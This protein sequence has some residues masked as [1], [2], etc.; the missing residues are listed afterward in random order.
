MRQIFFLLFLLPSLAFG[1]GWLDSGTYKSWPVT[2]VTWF[3]GGVTSGTVSRISGSTD[4]TPSSTD[5]SFNYSNYPA[6]F[7]HFY[8]PTNGLWGIVAERTN[9]WVKTAAT[10]TNPAS[11][12][13]FVII[14]NSMVTLETNRAVV[15]AC[16]T[17]P[18]TNNYVW[19]NVSNAVD[20]SVWMT[21]VPQLIEWDYTPLVNTNHMTT[22]DT[23]NEDLTVT[24]TTNGVSAYQ[25]I[26][27]WNI[28]CPEIWTYDSTL[29]ANEHEDILGITNQTWQ[30]LP[31][32]DSIE[33]AAVFQNLPP[34]KMWILSHAADFVMTIFTNS[35]GTFDDY[36]A[37]PQT[38]IVWTLRSGPWWNGVAIYAETNYWQTNITYRPPPQWSDAMYL[39]VSGSNITT[40]QPFEFAP[41]LTVED[42]LYVA[43]PLPYH[44][45]SMVVTNTGAFPGWRFGFNYIQFT[46]LTQI[47][48]NYATVAGYFRNTPDK[49]HSNYDCG[50]RHVNTNHWRFG[51]LNGWLPWQADGSSSLDT[52]VTNPLSTLGSTVLNC[53]IPYYS[54]GW[55]GVN[56]LCSNSIFA[57]YQILDYTIA[58]ATNTV[59]TATNIVDTTNTSH[60]AI[61]V[62]RMDYNSLI[63]NPAVPCNSNVLFSGT[64]NTSNSL[65]VAATTTNWNVADGYTEQAYEF[66]GIRTCLNSLTQ[67]IS[68][69][70]TWYD[71][72]IAVTVSNDPPT[73]QTL[74]ITND[75]YLVNR[76]GSNSVSSLL[77]TNSMGALWVINSSITTATVTTNY[78]GGDPCDTAG[79]YTYTTNGLT[80]VITVVDCSTTTTDY[81]WSV[82]NTVLNAP[83]VY[84]DTLALAKSAIIF[85]NVNY[86]DPRPSGASYA[87]NQPQSALYIKKNWTNSI[88]VASAP[89]G[90]V[91][92]YC[93]DGIIVGETSAYFD[94]C[95]GTVSYAVGSGLSPCESATN[96]IC[97][98]PPIIV[99]PALPIVPCFCAIPNRAAAVARCA[100]LGG[101]PTA[102][103]LS[104]LECHV[105]MYECTNDVS[106]WPTITVSDCNLASVISY[107][108]NYQTV[109][110]SGTITQ[111]GGQNVYPMWPDQTPSDFTYCCVKDGVAYYYV[112]TWSAGET[113]TNSM[114]SAYA[115]ST[116]AIPGATPTSVVMLFE[117]QQSSGGAFSDVLNK[118][119]HSAGIYLSGAAPSATGMFRF[120]KLPVPATVADGW[121]LVPYTPSIITT[122]CPTRTGDYPTLWTYYTTT[123]TMPTV[124][125]SHV[126]AQA[127]SNV[128]GSVTNINWPERS[129]W[130]P[131]SAW[132]GTQYCYDDTNAVGIF[133]KFRVDAPSTTNTLTVP[134]FQSTT[135]W[136]TSSSVDGKAYG[137]S[138]D[139]VRIL[140]NWSVTNGLPHR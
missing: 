115:F 9:I 107:L 86:G 90:T 54:N 119:A 89:I 134:E 39:D 5:W 98:G 1:T 2:N 12:S 95:D 13:D 94:F 16:L 81:M 4:V 120:E 24:T 97:F 140:L 138:V 21:N 66:D 83:L 112:G 58:V 25:M 129:I 136:V 31:P 51:R 52:V 77:D 109:V 106:T 20:C 29:A 69:P 48:T 15:V 11:C 122:S 116:P 114:N 100:A 37:A 56:I 45:I 23:T 22:A 76:Y 44:R 111:T 63:T 91:V 43:L 47:V 30:R 14:T 127:S 49:H 59:G 7:F 32:A 74:L 53:T 26:T 128:W 67:I 108:T 102:G 85:T 101:L 73:C 126:M 64:L 19:A 3:P 78:T 104:P 18:M 123:T 121:T 135:P 61:N 96:V 93:E 137:W 50:L 88:Q 113:F 62:I 110:D 72:G 132:T 131:P 28:N 6:T 117:S 27:N 41:Q 70:L 130:T 87:K 139:D 103:D 8:S 124:S 65:A 36:C 118:Y 34:W 71:T 80:P 55:T 75:L 60:V 46:N 79:S 84:T 68:P 57:T 35:S 125:V 33:A 40:V 82:T 17:D 42:K 133:Q 38:S 99:D 10:V 105:P 92:H